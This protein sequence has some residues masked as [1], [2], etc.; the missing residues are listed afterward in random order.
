MSAGKHNIN[1]E[2]GA[3]FKLQLTVSTND[4]TPVNL[5]GYQV[6]GQ[7]RIQFEDTTPT[8]TFTC[9]ITD[10]ANGKVEVTLSAATTTALSFTKGVYD[11]ELVTPA[12]NVV[13]LL[14]GNAI[15]S[16][17]VTK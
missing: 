5:V 8:A 2:Q 17:E 6:R 4:G 10:A 1:I 14:K 13:R 7:V 11:I 3:T 12:S 16:K 15:L 9:V